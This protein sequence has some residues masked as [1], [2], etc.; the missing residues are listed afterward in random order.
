MS[1]SVVMLHDAPQP[2]ECGVVRKWIGRIPAWIPMMIVWIPVIVWLV[3]RLDDGSDEPLGLLALAF[4]A[5][6]GWRDRSSNHPHSAARISGAL[7]LFLSTASIGVLPPMIRAGLAIIGTG[8]WFGIQRKPALL[9]LFLLSLPMV[10]S[11]QFYIGWPMRLA[12]AE[13]TVRLLELGGVVI[14]RQGVNIDI[15]GCRI[16][17]DPACGGILMLWHALA[18]AMALSAIHRVSWKATF[19][20]A[21]LAILLVIPA[22]IL[23]TTWLVIEKSGRVLPSGISH[24]SIGLI[25]FLV[26]L[27]PLWWWNSRQSQPSEDATA[28]SS[29]G[30]FERLI[31]ILTAC[32]TPWMMLR[33][34]PRVDH[35]PVATLP[36][37]FTFNGVTLPLNT[38]PPSPGETAFGASFPGSLS[39]HRWGDGHVILRRVNEATRKLHLSQDCLRAAGFETTHSVTVRCSDGSEWSRFTAT[40]EDDRFVI[41]ERIVSEQDG[42][43]WTDAP[44]WYWSALAHPL[45]GPWRAET[46]ISR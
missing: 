3:K 4:A 18:A 26:V 27:L 21:G 20:S 16:G 19:I 45:N 30:S 17:V 8:A 22:N 1:H 13:G 25:C 9:G 11:L 10:A 32:M 40:R 46:V 15:G 7:L 6:L 43:T 31:L 37:E 5:A 36:K 41:H 2:E 34:Q 35:A 39:S 38:L 12:A 29:T 14:A 28:K 33:W 44:T 42:S 23:R 24:G